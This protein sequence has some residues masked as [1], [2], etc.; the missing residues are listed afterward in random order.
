MNGHCDLPLPRELHCGS[1]QLLLKVF[2][3]LKATTNLDVS[4]EIKD[5]DKADEEKGGHLTHFWLSIVLDE[6]AKRKSKVQCGV[7]NYSKRG[8]GVPHAYVRGSEK[9][10]PRG[11]ELLTLAIDMVGAKRLGYVA[12][13]GSDAVAWSLGDLCGLTNDFFAVE[14]HSSRDN[15]EVFFTVKDHTNGVGT[16]FSTGM[17]DL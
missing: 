6:T 14:E 17:F 8:R 1:D 4:I 7:T 13:D 9:Y 11:V 5:K 16:L 10:R 3:F 12:M 2:Y 15:G